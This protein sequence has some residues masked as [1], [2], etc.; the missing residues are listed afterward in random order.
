M[1]ILEVLFEY[2]NGDFL[3]KMIFLFLLFKSVKIQCFNY[4][5][6]RNVLF[7]IKLIKEAINTV[8][9]NWFQRNKNGQMGKLHLK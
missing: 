6:F 3:D 9:L 5:I 8:K 4:K 7:Y 2:F 1:F